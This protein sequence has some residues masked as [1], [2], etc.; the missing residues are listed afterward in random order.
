L[1]AAGRPRWE[2]TVGDFIS[3]LF[4]AAWFGIGGREW[5]GGGGNPYLTP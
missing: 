4:I 3:E 2:R 5:G 1:L